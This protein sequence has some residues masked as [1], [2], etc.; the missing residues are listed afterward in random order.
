M[1]GINRLMR[2]GA[3]A[4]IIAMGL[5]LTSNCLSD[6]EPDNLVINPGF[7]VDEDK[8]GVPDG[9]QFDG[10][11]KSGGE[12][13]LSDISHSGLRSVRIR[14]KGEGNRGFGRYK[15]K[16][17]SLKPNTRYHFQGYVMA[18]THIKEGGYSSGRV[19]LGIFGAKGEKLEWLDSARKGVRLGGRQDT[20]WTQLATTFTTED[21]PSQVRIECQLLGICG[22]VWFDDVSVIEE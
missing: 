2:Y 6:E 10:M 20:S 5:L 17:I 7:E 15:S 12:G 16:L 3:I 13:K 8:D 1:I 19:V 9:W 22:E 18:N 4:A 21:A 11:G 14:Y